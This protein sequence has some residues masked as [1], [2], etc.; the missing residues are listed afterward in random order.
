MRLCITV[1]KVEGTCAAGYKKG[2][3]FYFENFLVKSEI[4]VCIHALSAMQNIIYALSHGINPLGTEKVYVRCP[5]PGG[6]L[7]AGSVLFKINIESVVD[8]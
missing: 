2:D 6:S 4:P 7:G 1:E 8:D 5:D 3:S